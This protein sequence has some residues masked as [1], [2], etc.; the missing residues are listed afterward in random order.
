MDD[1][2]NTNAVAAEDA[3]KRALEHHQHG[4]LL[5][6]VREYALTVRLSPFSPDAYNNFGVALRALG[7]PHAAIA[8]YRRS[9]AIRP[10]AANVL[11]NLGNAF[12]DL[13]LVAQAIAAHTRAIKISPNA[14]NAHFNAALAYRDAGQVTTALEHFQKSLAIDPVNLAAKLEMGIS[15]LMAGEWQEGFQLLDARLKMP[16]HAPKRKDI[17]LWQGEQL[18]RRTIL[19]T[20]EGNP[21]TQVMIARFARSL[22]LLGAK[23]I[24][25]APDEAA[26]LLRLSPDIDKV[27]KIGANA[28]NVDFQIP[29]LSLPGAL[30]TT[31]ENIPNETPYLRPPVR[32][33]HELEINP[34]VK[35]AL[36][37]VWSDGPSTDARHKAGA[38]KLE[39]LMEIVGLPGLMAFSLTRGEP[40]EEIK[41][42]GA[43]ELVF[44]AVDKNA[45]L[46]TLAGIIEQLD[47]IITVDSAVAHVAGAMGKPTWLL[48]APGGDWCW[49]LE[50]NDTPWY[51]SIRIFRK[52]PTEG[53]NDLASRVRKSLQDVLKGEG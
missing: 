30:K 36:G 34:N 49:L 51:P 12:R 29:L 27:I 11:T 31:T 52:N 53:W 2:K 37:L 20:H 33:S 18:S 23:I 48:T 45:D 9:V 6:A 28:G 21:G 46:A 42:I 13:G 14:A 38:C 43:Q 35:L 41:E 1:N 7:R 10:R 24:M 26:N 32:P 19:I 15:L 40:Q 3:Y 50:R 22:K 5:D 16:E 25:E 17:T 44:N 39:E 4:R 8:C 47:L